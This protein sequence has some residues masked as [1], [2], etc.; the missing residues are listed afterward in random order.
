M[1]QVARK[2]KCWLRGKRIQA[3]ALQRECEPMPEPD[4]ACDYQAVFLVEVLS[5]YRARR[6]AKV[7][8][9]RFGTLY[10]KVWRLN[11]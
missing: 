2:G 1:H 11:W 10:H 5:Q 3:N 6:A 4:R 7:L 8:T 9:P